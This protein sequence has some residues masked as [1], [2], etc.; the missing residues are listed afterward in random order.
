MNKQTGD[1]VHTFHWDWDIWIHFSLLKLVRRLS[2]HFPF[3]ELEI[4][5]HFNIF[6]LCMCLYIL[7]VSRQMSPRERSN[8]S[9]LPRTIIPALAAPAPPTTTPIHSS[10]AG[11]RF[12]Q[13]TSTLS[14]CDVRW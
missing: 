3:F 6:I 14:K 8:L 9:G 4:D 7:L 5:I 2:S 13:N 1:T 11:P 12:I 10:G